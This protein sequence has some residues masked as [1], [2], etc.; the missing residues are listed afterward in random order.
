VNRRDLQILADL[1]IV[2]AKILIDGSRFSGAYYLLGYAVE[3]ALKAC[4]AKQIKEHDFPDKQLVLDSYTHNL[5]KL[6]R[7]SGVKLMFDSLIKTNQSFE[8]NWNIVKDWTEGSRYDNNVSEVKA[9]DLLNAVTD[10][11]DGVLTWLKTVW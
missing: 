2:D 5:E 10:G 11:T 1:R 4:I 8:V 6:L 7:I 9:R 3:C